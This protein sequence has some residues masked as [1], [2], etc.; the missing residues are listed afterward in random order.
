MLERHCTG[1]IREEA[2]ITRVAREDEVKVAINEAGIGY[3]G[4]GK[5]RFGTDW[6]GGGEWTFVDES[7]LLS[8]PH[9][10]PYQA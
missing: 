3:K 10:R 7:F 6:D 8:S 5:C 1:S 4:L 2:A 9:A